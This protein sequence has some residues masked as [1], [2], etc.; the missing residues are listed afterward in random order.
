MPA[1][2]KSVRPSKKTSAVLATPLLTLA[3]VAATATPAA[4][5]PTTRCSAY[6]Y[7]SAPVV[8]NV[9]MKTCVVKNGNSRY[10][11][12]LV[13]QASAYSGSTWDLF[14]VHARLEKSDANKATKWCDFTDTMNRHQ[15]PRVTCQ[16]ATVT[17]SSTGGW[18][19]DAVVVFNF[20]LDGK[21]DKSRAL[22]GSPSVS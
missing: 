17:S 16:T 18:T 11:Y 21:G 22:T 12:V 6:Q 9:A 15:N 13:E 8:T 14:K 5:A 3:A 10:A 4:A 20:N 7:Q 19:S 2:W 1:T